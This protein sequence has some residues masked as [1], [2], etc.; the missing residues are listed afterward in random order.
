MNEDYIRAYELPDKNEFDLKR[1]LIRM[2]RNWQWFVLSIIVSFGLGYF[3]L[4]VAHPV[5]YAYAAILV[6]DDKKGAEIMDNSV[7]KEMGLG[8][9]NKLVENETEVLK[10]PDLMEA[11]VKKLKLYI[12]AN[13]IGKFRKISVF[14]NEIPFQMEVANIDKIKGDDNDMIEW[15]IGKAN[16]GYLF[17]NASD[18]EFKLLKYGESYTYSGI[19]F[20]CLSNPNYSADD[21]LAQEKDTNSNFYDIKLIPLNEATVKFG[22]KLTVEQATK[23]ATVINLGMKDENQSRGISILRSL[24]D[25]YNQLGL[26]DKNRVTDSTI[27]FLNERLVAIGND[28]R[29]IDETVESFKTKNKVT[30]IPSNVEQ[31]MTLSKDIDQQKAES[32]TQLNIVNALEKD[33]EDNQDNPKLVPSTL[34]IEEPSL[35]LLI[36]QHN[37]L[38]L[39]KERIEEKSGPQ[40]P[41][42]LDLEGQ[43]KEIRAKMLASVHNLKQAYKI[44]EQDVTKV[45]AEL[46][47]KIQ[48]VPVMERKFLEITRDKDVHDQIYAFL[49]QK[50]E[51]SEVTLASNVEDSRTISQPRSLGKKWP[52]GLIVFGLCFLIGLAIPIA[53]IYAK[54]FL[55]NKVGDSAQVAQF[56]NLPML[57]VISHMKK[58]KTPVVIGTRSRSVVA[59]QIRQIR[60][61]ISFTGKGKEI[62]KVLTT[63][64]QPGDGKSFVSLNLA[65]GYALLEKKTVILEFD[66]RRP[67]L[68]KD[69]GLV[70]KEGISS[71]L[72]G[73]ST[74]DELLIELPGFNGYLYLLPAGIIPPNP[75]ELISG[76]RMQALMKVLEKR[77]DYVIIDTPP[78]GVVADATLLQQ[79]SDIS[80][81]VL[82]QDHTSREVYSQLKDHV[83]RHPEHSVYLLLNDVGRSK[84]Y[85]NGY[86]YNYGKG[87]YNQ[88][89]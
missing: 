53:V 42:L 41:L 20:Y 80:L 27:S 56:I 18:K 29:K 63:S 50:R 57:G 43:I 25:S 87:Y 17:K 26:D 75:A 46:S 16:G 28:M 78:F 89:E 39:Q 72:S 82:R 7:L 15:I 31:Y 35:S 60:T 73:K 36:E 10:S 3:F 30:D 66:L 67:H 65:A 74:V 32:E 45:D 8:G 2:I 61:A 24:I 51:E 54:D 14:Q 58:I 55:H 85:Q 47:S 88:E 69:L 33:L 5:F 59:E 86:N 44:A 77:F 83:S 48:N 12:D 64:F 68:T 52:K 4:K 70:E 22:S 49:L 79:Y 11:V 13:R 9:D 6:K 84:R 71:I 38:L 21:E 40:N 76:T 62:K 1:W 19:T 81:V 34:G 37:Q 23:L